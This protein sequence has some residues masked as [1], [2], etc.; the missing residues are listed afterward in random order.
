[1]E[2]ITDLLKKTPKSILVFIVIVLG[3]LG[4]SLFSNYLSNVEKSIALANSNEKAI[5]KVLVEYESLNEKFDEKKKDDIL[6]RERV[7][8]R[9]DTQFQRII[10]R[11]D[12]MRKQKGG[13]RG[14]DNL[15]ILNEKK[16]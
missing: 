7:Q 10:D 1:M 3:F 8:H 14:V 15:V 13:H 4:I 9:T 11:L 2:I 16:Y 5:V 12:A 6:Y